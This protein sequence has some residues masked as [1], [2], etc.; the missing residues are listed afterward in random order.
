MLFLA[1]SLQPFEIEPF[2]LIGF[3]GSIKFHFYGTGQPCLQVTAIKV[4][5]YLS[6]N[7]QS[8]LSWIILQCTIPSGQVK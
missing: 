4:L 3:C 7:L 6:K 8:K 2:S 5:H 1:F